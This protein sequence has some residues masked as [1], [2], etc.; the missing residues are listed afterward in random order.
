MQL[1]KLCLV[2]LF[3]L[4]GAAHSVR[5]EGTVTAGTSLFREQGGPLNMDVIMPSVNAAVDV[6]QPLQ[7]RVGWMADI[8][9]GASVAVVDAPADRVDAITTAT[10]SDTRHQLAGGLTLRDTQGSVDVT[11]NHAFENDY[12]SHNFAVTAR[13]DLRDRNTGFEIGYSRSFDRV[14]DVA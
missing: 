13:T 1:T 2:T 14:C 4:L 3:V 9:S 11:Y 10:V 6:A 12:R 5:A 8:V 7:L